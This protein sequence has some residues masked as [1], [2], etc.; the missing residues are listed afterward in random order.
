M[1]NAPRPH[2]VH[3]GN[4]SRVDRL[5]MVVAQLTELVQSLAFGQQAMMQSRAQPPQPWICTGCY[6]R[7]LQW[8]AEHASQI[9]Q[10]QSMVQAETALW[11]SSPQDRPQPRNLNVVLAEAFDAVPPVPN[12]AALLITDPVKGIRF[13]CVEHGT[14]EQART[15]LLVATANVNFSQLTQR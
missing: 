12:L 15:K 14:P 7:S 6:E 2:P 8:E 9:R 10:A 3:N 11:Q 1:S 13:V 4:P 5:E